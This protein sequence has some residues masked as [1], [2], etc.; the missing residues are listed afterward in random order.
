MKKPIVNVADAPGRRGF[1]LMYLPH[2]LDM[3]GDIK[4]DP[5]ID[6]ALVEFTTAVTAM[7]TRAVS[8]GWADPGAKR[9]GINLRW[10]QASCSQR[11]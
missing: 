6:R 10:M 1:S 11:P 9:L 8:Y 4:V 5:G 2:H 3:N 7:A